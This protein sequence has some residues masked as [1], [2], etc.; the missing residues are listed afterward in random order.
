MVYDF[1]TI[2]IGGG[3]AGASAAIRV[4]YPRSYKSVTSSVAILDDNG[5]GGLFNCVGPR[6]LTGPSWEYT[7]HKLMGKLKSD[8][9]KFNIPVIKEE[10]VSSDLYTNS[11]LKR[12]KTRKKEYSAL[13]IIVATGIK[14]TGNEGDYY[15]KGVLPTLKDH[16]YVKNM[17]EEL[18]TGCKGE[19][20]TVVGSEKVLRLWEF[21]N[22]MND[23]RV[24]LKL[25]VEPPYTSKLPEE[26]IR[27]R[28]KRVSGDN[29]VERIH[30]LNRKNEQTLDTDH[31]I[32]DFESYELQNTSTTFLDDLDMIDGFIRVDNQM[33]T[34]RPGVF[35]A[36]DVTGPP[37][38]V[39]KAMDQGGIAG[40]SA[41][42]YTFEFKFGQKPPLYAYYPSESPKIDLDKTAFK[43]PEIKPHYKPK[44]LGHLSSI[45]NEKE[46]QIVK[47]FDGRHT[48]P[49]IKDRLS[50][51]GVSGNL[52]EELKKLYTKLVEQKELTIHI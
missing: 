12:I 10:V 29:R 18:F 17:L 24:D 42:R 19:R 2:V 32:I 44:F 41:Y 40:F 51:M 48:F 26:A 30:F 11:K 37:F 33:R 1:D 16:R 31:V 28:M 47:L 15:E 14:K 27:G 46:E 49:Q 50:F 36:G 8:I 45:Q 7:A 34:N 4:R 38:A 22:E 3:F 23:G 13:S 39:L 9:E 6:K 5:L 35:A 25:L 52:D 21:V 20:V 43:V